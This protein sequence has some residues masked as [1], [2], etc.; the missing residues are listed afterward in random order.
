MGVR[1]GREGCSE[2][3]RVGLEEVGVKEGWEG[4]GEGWRVG[5]EGQ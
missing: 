1:V 5:L 4:A 2:G 3:C